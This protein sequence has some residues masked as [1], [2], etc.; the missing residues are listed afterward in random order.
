MF[1]VYLLYFLH[2]LHLAVSFLEHR[3]VVSQ[4]HHLKAGKM[5]SKEALKG[6]DQPWRF[7][8]LLKAN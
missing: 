4:S 6:G 8:L 3:E 2:L 1:L 5:A 7:D